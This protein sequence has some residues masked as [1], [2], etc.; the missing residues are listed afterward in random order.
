MF[1]GQ[2]GARKKIQA[3]KYMHKMAGIPDQ[4]CKTRLH[5]LERSLKLNCG[6]ITMPIVPGCSKLCLVAFHLGHPPYG[7]S[8]MPCRYLSL[9]TLW[10]SYFRPCR[11]TSWPG[12]PGHFVFRRLGVRAQKP[13]H[14]GSVWHLMVTI[15]KFV[16]V[17]EVLGVGWGGGGGY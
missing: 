2:V 6:P 8:K 17:Y 12:W 4:Q 7:G 14:R 16:P 13:W 9:D 15:Y 10:R 11:G 1:S 5:W 3:S